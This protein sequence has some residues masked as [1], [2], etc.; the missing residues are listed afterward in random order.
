LQE[1]NALEED[2]LNERLAGA[3][4]VPVHLPPGA[5]KAP[6][7]EFSCIVSDNLVYSHPNLAA[8]KVAVEDDEEAQLRELQ[9]QLAL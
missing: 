2:V 8:K 7:G 3:D 1:L 9:A 4:H 5:V 6:E